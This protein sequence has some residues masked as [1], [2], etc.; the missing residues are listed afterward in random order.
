MAFRRLF[1]VA[2]RVAFWTPFWVP[3]PE[4]SFLEANRTTGACSAHRISVP[5]RR[6]LF[7]TPSA[8]ENASRTTGAC[9]LHRTHIPYRRRAFPVPN[10]TTAERRRALLHRIFQTARKEKA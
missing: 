9:F 8:F 5:Y 2:F 7:F 3:S 4:G 6:S 10:A 1:R